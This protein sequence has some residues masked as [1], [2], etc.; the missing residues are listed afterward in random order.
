MTRVAIRSVQSGRYLGI[1]GRGINSVVKGGQGT[2][3]AQT[4]IGEWETWILHIHPGNI[5]AF[6]SAEFHNVYLRLLAED[7]SQGNLVA[8]GGGKVNGQW[9]CSTR[10]KYHIRKAEGDKGKRGI[11]GIESQSEPGKF[12]RV[13]G[14]ENIVNVQGVMRSYEEFEVLIISS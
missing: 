11:V 7:V 3:F 5:V 10:E 13:K 8:P 14:D 12:L 6:E 2:V 1:D 4:Q 9:G